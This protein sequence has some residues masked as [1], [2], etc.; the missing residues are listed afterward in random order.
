MAQWPAA[1]PQLGVAELWEAAQRLPAHLEA[2]RLLEADPLALLLVDHAAEGLCLERQQDHG[3]RAV[4]SPDS[5]VAISAE[6]QVAGQ[7]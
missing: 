6:P 4:P 5:P 2:G 3:L 1:A 7:T